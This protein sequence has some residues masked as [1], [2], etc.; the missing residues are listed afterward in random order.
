MVIKLDPGGWE[1][2]QNQFVGA[3]ALIGGDDIIWIDDDVIWI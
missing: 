1:G 3:K 2:G